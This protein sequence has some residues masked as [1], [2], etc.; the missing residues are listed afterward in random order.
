MA[1]VTAIL[2]AFREGFAVRVWSRLTNTVRSEFTEVDRAPQQSRCSTS[3][4][5][6]GSAYDLTLDDA[7]APPSSSPPQASQPLEGSQEPDALS[8]GVSASAEESPE[9]L[10]SETDEEALPFVHAPHVPRGF[11][12]DRVGGDAR[13]TM[14]ANKHVIEQVGCSM[15]HMLHL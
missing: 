15:L 8:G 1:W 11:Q 10:D 3:G 6:V 13:P 4:S 5:T 14:L 2:V 9:L 12:C 7:E